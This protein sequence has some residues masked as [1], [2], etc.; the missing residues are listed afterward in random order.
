MESLEEKKEIVFAWPR[1]SNR[2][3][4]TVKENPKVIE[5]KQGEKYNP[6]TVAFSQKCFE[7]MNL[8]ND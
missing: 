7:A 1:E 8:S 3:A 4:K 6:R 2:I 5:A